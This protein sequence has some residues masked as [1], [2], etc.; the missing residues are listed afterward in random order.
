MLQLVVV[1]Q[2]CMTMLEQL[3]QSPVAVVAAVGDTVRTMAVPVEV[4]MAAMVILL[5]VP[6]EAPLVLEELLLQVEP[7]VREM[8]VLETQP[9]L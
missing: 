3:S 8:I 7:Q 1:D 2:A 6:V 5:V 9:V 4:L